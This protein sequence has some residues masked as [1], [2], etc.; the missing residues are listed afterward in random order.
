M[1]K[2]QI[3][4]IACAVS[5]GLIIAGGL[6]VSAQTVIWS[7]TFPGSS[8]SSMDSG[9]TAGISGVDGGAGGALPQSGA[10]VQQ[11]N[12]SG[13][14][15]LLTPSTSGGSGWIRFDTIGSSSTLYNWAA[16]PGASA[17]TAAGGMSISFN[18]TSADTTSGNWI[19]V[20]A[21]ASSSSQT[22]GGGSGSY[23]SPY[24]NGGGSGILFK[25]NGGTGYTGGTGSAPGFS[26][27]GGASHTVTLDYSF[28]SWAVGAPVTV[29]AIVDGNV[30][31]TDSYTWQNA[32]NYISIG[33]YQENGN[34]LSN[35]EITTVPEPTTWAIMA[36]GLGML[37]ATRRFRRSNA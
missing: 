10:I 37:V 8:G 13:G 34:V 15:N 7:D 6:S 2:I 27:A 17:I 30:A 33:T 16:S 35:L 12:G 19:F 9:S 24:F 23:T 14:V 32:Y 5:A 25:N 1:K 36:A 18:W 31:A 20:E 11:L 22:T 21:G 28:T 26:V 3:T 4:K 29:S